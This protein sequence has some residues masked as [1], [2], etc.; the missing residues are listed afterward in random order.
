MTNLVSCS[1]TRLFHPLPHVAY[2]R[3]RR[4]R[5]TCIPAET[6]LD[7]HNDLPGLGVRIYLNETKVYVEQTHEPGKSKRATT[8]RHG[9]F[10]MDKTLRRARPYHQHKKMANIRS[11][12]WRK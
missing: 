10:T 8:G 1:E 2:L 9:L 7:P 4:V 3:C 6:Y 11:G 5:Q 12:H